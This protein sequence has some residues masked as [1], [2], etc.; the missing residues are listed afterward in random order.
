MRG[1][2]FF[3]IGNYEFL[4]KSFRNEVH[5]GRVE[6]GVKRP[7]A[8]GND[9]G[10][11]FGFMRSIDKKSYIRRIGVLFTMVLILGLW[12]C[13]NN[14]ENKVSDEE[15]TSESGFDMAD[16][17][18]EKV[19]KQE[20]EFADYSVDVKQFGGVYLN[21][22]LQDTPEDKKREASLAKTNTEALK[23]AI[24]KVSEYEK[25]GKKGG[26]VVISNGYFYTGPI[27]LESN[28]N[29]HLEDDAKVLFTTDYSQYPNVLC[30]WEGVVCYNYSP[31][32]YAYQKENIAVTGK[33]TFYGQATKE[34]YWLPWKNGSVNLKE[35]QSE[36]KKRIRQM[37]QEQTP[38]EERVFG[39]GSYLRPAFA[40]PFEC[41]N[42]LLENITIKDAPF[43]MVHPVFCEN[44]IIRGVTV[45][46][47]GYN[48][49]GIN[50]DSCR[51]VLIENCVLNTGDDAIAIKSGLN[52]DGQVYGKP[53]E[54]IVVQNNTYLTGK[55]SAA[56][57]GSDMSGDVRYIFFRDNYARES[58]EHLQSISIKTNGD[59]GG[60][61]EHIYIS[62]LKAEHVE[63]YSV[64]I[65]M[66]YEEGDT[67]L[68]TPIIRDIYIKDCQ[69]TG[70]KQGTIGMVGYERSPIQNIYFE[71]CEFS[72]CQSKFALWNAEKIFFKDVTF[73][74]KPYPDGEYIPNA[75]SIEILEESVSGS[76]RVRYS[77][78]APE[79]KIKT[80]WYVCDTQDGEY[81]PVKENDTL[82]AHDTIMEAILLNIEKTKY[83]KLLIE[84]EGKTYWTQCYHRQS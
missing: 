81:V 34:K 79:S 64:Y 2:S 50:P 42:V 54:Y 49:D 70:G 8:G 9:N 26:K 25:D 1:K 69:L 72:N 61:V 65:T 47:F 67:E 68:T 45:N 21:S 44:V 32:I 11:G 28:V 56:T 52:K 40:E 35:C 78:G 53:S 12:G 73:N 83:Y 14:S 27:Q 41:T 48:N 57:V 51:Y 18:V 33:G 23:K 39:E 71:N 10:G 46:S 7:D 16:E 19:L 30:R 4:K 6:D 31:F 22:Q 77:C 38:V 20:P 15:T 76:I 43:W 63:D 66:E 74:E 5:C 82:S 17:V 62:G 37:G 80:Q 3:F 59:R 58:C 13:R 55:G 84:V 29:L 60:I 36:A 24:K 75:D